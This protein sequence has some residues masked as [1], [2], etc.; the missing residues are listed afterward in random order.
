[1][2]TVPGVIAEGLE[3]VSGVL[4]EIEQLASFDSLIFGL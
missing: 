2:L 3:I 4:L 1:M